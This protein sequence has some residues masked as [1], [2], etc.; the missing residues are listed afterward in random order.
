MSVLNSKLILT[1]EVTA[2][3]SPPSRVPLRQAGDLVAPSM[4]LASMQV[5][6]NGRIVAVQKC[7]YSLHATSPAVAYGGCGCSR[8]AHSVPAMAS[9]HSTAGWRMHAGCRNVRKSE[10]A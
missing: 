4:T 9:A 1:A 10:A 8:S 5:M 6:A 7:L 3:S 2:A